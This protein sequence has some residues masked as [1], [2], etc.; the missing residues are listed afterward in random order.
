M[1]G[2][3]T[4]VNM[5]LNGWWGMNKYILGLSLVTLIGC[6]SGTADKTD[7][8]GRCFMERMNDTH[9]EVLEYVY[10]DSYIIAIYPY[11]R[12]NVVSTSYIIRGSKEINCRLLRK[13]Y[14]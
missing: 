4:Y 2:L 7:L 14:E 13:V 11:K 1:T 12:K 6:S 3:V 10:P 8:E 5:A 9:Y